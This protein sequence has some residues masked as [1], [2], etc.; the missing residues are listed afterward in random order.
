MISPFRAAF[1]YARY[2]FVSPTPE[3]LL[4]VAL[5]KNVPVFGIRRENE[6]TLALS[7]MVFREKHLAPFFSDLKPGES[8]RRRLCGL[9]RFLYRYRRRWGFALGAALTVFLTALST[10]YLWS[11]EVIGNAAVPDQVIRAELEACGVA[12]GV[13]ISDLDRLKKETEFIVAHPEY[14]YVSINVVGT[15]ARVEV[16][17][18]E[19]VEEKISYEGASNLVAS[20]GGVV[21][22]YEVLSGQIAVRPGEGVAEGQLLVSGVVENRAGAFRTVRAAGR[23][24]LETHRAFEVFIPLEREETLYTGKERSENVYSVLG[25]ESGSGED[26]CPFAQYAEEYEEER[27]TIFGLPLPVLKK[28]RVF[29]ETVTVK[30]A[31]SIDRA[32]KLSYD[33]FEEWKRE[34][35]PD[36]TEILNESVALSREADGVRLTA[37]LDLVE[38][39]AVEAP[40]R[41]SFDPSAPS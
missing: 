30:N 32:E 39:A 29:R 2:T 31:I 5:Q 41:V 6:R 10:R 22:R 11:V 25:V 13:R 28:S 23:V 37:E 35:L 14:S 17:E 8:Y 33:R 7:V 40:F 26:P 15:V 38:N 20:C 18:R 36:G 4:Q 16:R 12:P 19:E 3:R 1:G 24:F 9:P 34:T 21:R 27:V